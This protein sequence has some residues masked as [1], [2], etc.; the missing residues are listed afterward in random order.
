M[1]HTFSLDRY[2]RA[3]DSYADAVFWA[4]CLHETN[5]RPERLCA[6][7]YQI[8]RTYIGRGDVAKREGFE[9]PELDQKK[10]KKALDI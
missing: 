3:H 1:W 10:S 8:S 6:G 7:L 4:Q 9:F 5:D 2:E